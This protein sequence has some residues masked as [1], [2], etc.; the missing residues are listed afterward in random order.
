MCQIVDMPLVLPL[1]TNCG[2]TTDN[3]VLIGLPFQY[4]SVICTLDASAEALYPPPLIVYLAST[5][6]C[7][8]QAT[9]PPSM[10]LVRILASLALNCR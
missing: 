6:L 10:H 2:V 7:Y 1:P 5:C 3:L 9:Q 8:L 4:I